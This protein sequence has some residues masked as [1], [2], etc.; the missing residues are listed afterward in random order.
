LLQGIA[1]GS[2]T[3]LANICGVLA[4]GCEMETSKLYAVNVRN[5][6]YPTLSIKFTRNKIKIVVMQGLQSQ[7]SVGFSRSCWYLVNYY[8][9]IVDNQCKM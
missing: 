9:V 5:I 4:G 6:K 7:K 8:A 3:N 2:Y 1:V